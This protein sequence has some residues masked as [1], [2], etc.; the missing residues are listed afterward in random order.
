MVSPP[1][2][3][4]PSS[5]PTTLKVL[6]VKCCCATL[7]IAS[8]ATSHLSVLMSYWGAVPSFRAV[9]IIGADSSI[10]SFVKVIRLTL[11]SMVSP[12]KDSL[13]N[14]P[15]GSAFSLFFLF[16]K[17]DSLNYPPPTHRL[18]YLFL[19]LK[20]IHK[21]YGFGITLLLIFLRALMFTLICAQKFWLSSSV[22]ANIKLNFAGSMY[23]VKSCMSFVASLKS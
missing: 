13:I 1:C 6:L 18:R 19:L 11:F 3:S 4:V 22:C 16:C 20:A 17:F 12:S 23:V 7:S 21:N 14:I 10:G 9:Y 8:I 2:F 15:D 5:L